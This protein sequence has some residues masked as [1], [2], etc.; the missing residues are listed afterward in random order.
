MTLSVSEMQRISKDCTVSEGNLSLRTHQNDN[1]DGLDQKGRQTKRGRVPLE[2]VTNDDRRS[3]AEPRSR[4]PK[5]PTDNI[6]ANLPLKKRKTTIEA[7][8][9]TT[10]TKK[11]TAP[12]VAVYPGAAFA[13]SR[14]S[15]LPTASNLNSKGLSNPVW[16]DH[17][18]QQGQGGKGR[19]ELVGFG[20]LDVRISP[21]PVCY[22]LVSR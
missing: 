4:V 1:G 10:D 20:L 8:D 22:C 3:I 19:E 13:K 18:K 2:Q 9:V 14:K 6:R 21:L 16:I 12:R 15:A 11:P 17:F 5:P 7:N